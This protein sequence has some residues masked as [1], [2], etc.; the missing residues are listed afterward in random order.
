MNYMIKKGKYDK[1]FVE[2][3]GSGFDELKEGISH[4]N[5]DW[6]AKI[7]DIPAKQ[8]KE[9][10]KT[11]AANAPSVSIHPGRHV[12][13]YGND[14]QRGR[15]LACLTGLLG[16]VGAMGGFVKPKGPK[17]GKVSWPKGDHDDEHNIREIKD[18]HHF[19]PPGTPT[20]LIREAAVTGKPYPIKGFVAW[21]LNPI[22]TV[23]NQELTIKMLKQMDFVMVVDVMPTDITMFADI[24]LP[25]AS[26]LERYD[27]IKTGTQWNFADKH[28]QYISARMPLVP[29]M[30]ERKE[31][32]WITNEIAKRMGYGDKIPVKT[33]EEM[34][35]KRLAKANLSLEKLKKEDGIHIRPGK[36]PYSVPEDF[37]MIFFSEDLEDSGYPAVPTYKAVEDVPKGFARLVYGRSPVHTFNRSQNNVWLNH[38]MPENPIWLNDKNAKKMGIKDGDRVELVNQDGVMSRNSSIVKV[39]PGIRKDT[40]Y[41][42]HGYG[43]MNPELSAG[44]NKGIDDQAL[45]TK[46]AVDPESGAHG[47]RNNFVRFV[48]DGKV[49]SIPA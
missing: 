26:Y 15:A 33:A 23:P 11:L 5:L 49:I 43:S 14:F 2:E 29:S 4:A 21:G 22:Q 12:S 39:T 32:V 19:A 17:V 10:A 7:C 42:A 35:N 31:S 16:A 45:I 1:E 30:F 6:A 34:V 13:W 18:V 41:L 44:H 46:L 25:E 47:M 24:L 3:Y 40:I 9:V 27:Y 38:E 8:I 20:D 28:Q 37:E 36:S 48:K